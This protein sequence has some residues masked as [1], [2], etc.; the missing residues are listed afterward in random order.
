VGAA[1]KVLKVVK[2]CGMPER[3]ETAC[4]VANRDFREFSFGD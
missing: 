3:F 2:G 1:G 4:G